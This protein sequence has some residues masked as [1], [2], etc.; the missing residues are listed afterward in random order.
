MGTMN[1]LI[2]YLTLFF[3]KIILVS[4]ILLNA[5]IT[6]LDLL[7]IFLTKNGDFGLKGLKI[8]YFQVFELPSFPFSFLY[9]ITY[10]MNEKNNSIIQNLNEEDWKGSFKNPYNIRYLNFIKIL[11]LLMW[12]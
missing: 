11:E 4:I 9:N 8:L 2:Q 7:Y 6:N 1:Y 3:Q 5:G 12:N 10:R